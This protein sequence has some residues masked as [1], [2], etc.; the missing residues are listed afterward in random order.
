MGNFDGIHLGHRSVIDLARHGP[1]W[2]AD[3]R[4]APPRILCP[5]RAPLPPDE[6]RGARQP[7]GKLGVEHLYELPFDATL[8][9]L[10]PPNS[11]IRCCAEGLGVAH[12]V[13][14]ADFCFGKGRKGKPPICK[15]LAQPAASA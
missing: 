12:V 4:A 2:R 5:R 10:S 1:A 3:L 9:G 8:A 13:V 15:E 11:W 14:G 6:R 7:A